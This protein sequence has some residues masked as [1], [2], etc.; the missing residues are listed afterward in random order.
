MYINSRVHSYI[1]SLEFTLLEFASSGGD[2]CDDY[3]IWPKCSIYVLYYLWVR[4]AAKKSSSVSGPTT[5]S[6]TTPPSPYE[7]S[8]LFVG[9]F[10]RASKKVSLVVR[11][12]SPPPSPLCGR[13]TNEGTFFCVFPLTFLIILL[14]KVIHRDLAARNIL[15]TEDNVCKVNIFS[16]L[17][18]CIF[19]QQV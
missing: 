12:L 19:S 5:K 13:T 11:P 3:A 18:K 6:L 10:I 1:R 16:I 8:H 15:V 9:T 14:F 17:F 2:F 7:I 4:E